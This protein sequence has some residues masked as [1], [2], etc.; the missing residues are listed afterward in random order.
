MYGP[1]RPS[2]LNDYVA[3]KL[4]RRTGPSLRF[5]DIEN[6]NDPHD[7]MFREDIKTGLPKKLTR[8]KTTA[9]KKGRRR[10]E[11]GHG[12]KTKSEDTNRK[13]NSEKTKVGPARRM[14]LKWD[15]QGIVIEASSSDR[16]SSTA[17]ENT[18]PSPKRQDM[19][20][21]PPP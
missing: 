9:K 15:Q 17:S 14:S 19:K 7:E 3:Y 13:K 18:S 20:L 10:K 21:T 6:P 11:G 2:R 5:S 16:W 1:C 8:K 12:E 4:A